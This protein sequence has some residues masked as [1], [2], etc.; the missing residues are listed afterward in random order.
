MCRWKERGIVMALSLDNRDALREQLRPDIVALPRSYQEGGQV[1]HRFAR[2][3]KK[4]L[5]RD[6]LTIPLLVPKRTTRDAHRK[7]RRSRA[8]FT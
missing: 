5:R 2:V 6:S 1:L 3:E 4:G 7:S 8:A